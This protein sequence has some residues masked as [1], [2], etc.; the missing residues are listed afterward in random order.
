MLLSTTFVD[1]NFQQ[2]TSYVTVWLDKYAEPF[3]VSSILNKYRLLVTAFIFSVFFVDLNRCAKLDTSVHRG[4]PWEKLSSIREFHENL[5]AQAN[6]AFVDINAIK[7]KLN[8]KIQAIDE[9]KARVSETKSYAVDDLVTELRNSAIE[10]ANNL[11]ANCDE[12]IN[13]HTS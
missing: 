1:N 6:Q 7:E 13:K 5:R 4:F 10:S 3:D 12:Y 11:I 2:W 9:Q 8:D